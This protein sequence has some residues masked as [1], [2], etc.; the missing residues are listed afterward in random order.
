MFEEKIIA[1]VAAL[2]T[3]VWVQIRAVK[4]TAGVLRACP[5]LR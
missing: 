2:D 3:E 4:K 5:G 1:G